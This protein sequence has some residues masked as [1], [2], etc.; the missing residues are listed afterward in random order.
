MLT[1]SIVTDYMSDP[2]DQHTVSVLTNGMI[3]VA[4]GESESVELNSAQLYNS[5][6]ETWT[7]TGNM[8]D[9]R[10]FHTASMLQRE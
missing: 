2:G 3:S 8:N 4:A 5:S 6:T 7:R 9:R 1:G 10:K